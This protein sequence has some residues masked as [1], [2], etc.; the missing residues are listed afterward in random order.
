MKEDFFVEPIDG[1]R[2]SKASS[3]GIPNASDRSKKA[4]FSQSLHI[5][6]GHIL[7]ATVRLVDR[8]SLKPLLAQSIL[9]AGA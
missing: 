3:I 8:F 4:R 6:N 7:T 1:L 5:P 9:R 2:Q